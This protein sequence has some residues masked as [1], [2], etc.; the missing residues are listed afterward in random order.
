MSPPRSNLRVLIVQNE[1]PSPGGLINQWLDE[2]GADLNVLRIDIEDRDIDPR[3]Y[4]LLVPL[5]SEFAAYDESLP[6]VERS[7]VLLER[8]VEQDVPV[9]GVC[10]GGQLLAK[11]LGGQA[12]RAAESEIGWIPVRSH[13]PELVSEGPWFQWHFDGFST[14]PGARL[15]AETNAGPQVFVSGRHLG[16]QFHPEVTP[17][18]MEGWVRTYR[19]ELDDEGVDP[20]ALLE[21]TERRAEDNRQASRRLLRRYIDA[22]ARLGSE[23]V[24]ER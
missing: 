10:F 14:P 3:D 1:D 15:V 5:G 11:V 13:D 19:H 22:V 17:E 6:F 23:S 24:H 20:D 4:D 2:Q 7:R 21:E 9:L 16:V 18:I 8:A 12:F